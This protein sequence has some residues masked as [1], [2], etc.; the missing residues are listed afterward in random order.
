MNGARAFAQAVATIFLKAPKGLQAYQDDIFNGTRSIRAHLDNNQE[1]LNS[2]RQYDL[3]L[4]PSKC[5]FNYVKMKALGH[6]MVAGGYRVPDPAQVQA[7][8]DMTESPKTRKQVRSFF[9][10]RQLQRMLHPTARHH[11][12]TT[13]RRQTI[14]PGDERVD[15]RGTWRSDTAH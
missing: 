7:V 14:R 6:L 11:P 1:M 2:L 8:L 9:R 13:P 15:R 4:K 12:S 5:M 3:I 10:T